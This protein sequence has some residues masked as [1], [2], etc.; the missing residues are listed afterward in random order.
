MWSLLLGLLPGA[1]STING[2]T[3]AIANE[4]IAGLNAQTEQER[5][6]SQERVSAL[7]AK[8]DIMIAE[9][10]SPWNGLMRF[11]LA[12]GPA[13][14]LLKFF[15]WDKAIGSLAGCAGEAGQQ[16]SCITFRTDPLDTNQW[17]VIT[18]VIGFYFLY[19]GV[20]QFKR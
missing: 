9:S 5:I 14:I 15:A 20:R 18:A 12:L 13:I 11:I 19:E 7:Q 4:R 6:A 17:A 16:L 2:I 8:R 1:F 10:H 3:N